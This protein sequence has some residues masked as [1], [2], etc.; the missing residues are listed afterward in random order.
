MQCDA[1]FPSAGRGAAFMILPAD[2]H[3]LPKW[4]FLLGDAVLL[5]T[6]WLID[7]DGRAPASGATLAAVVA[8]V[9]LGAVL[10]VI[11]F[12][13]EYARRQ[14]EALDERQRALEALSRTVAASA[15]Q[16]GIAAHGLHEISEL[17]Q[18]NLKA[19]EQLP[20][21]LQEKLTGLKNQRDGER[22]TDR[23]EFRSELA[24]SRAA[25]EE[26]LDRA[27]EKIAGITAAL[28]RL[29][30][31]RPSS[32]APANS[33]RAASS[34]PPDHPAPPPHEAETA[35]ASAGIPDHPV[36][37]APGTASQRAFA[38]E[39]AVPGEP[40]AAAAA[41]SS[42]G[43]GPA[44]RPLPPD[45]VPPT[46]PGIAPDSSDTGFAAGA[47]P[48]PRPERKRTPRKP[49]P[50]A[51]AADAAELPAAPGPSTPGESSSPAPAPAVPP[52]AEPAIPSSPQAE[53]SAAETA[54]IRSADGATRL[55][56]TAY[57]GI[58]N[59]LFIRGSGPGLSWD[60]GL[61]LQFVSIG[62]WR[63]ETP[64]SAAVQFK[65]FKN[66]DV[67]CLALGVQTIAAGHQHE[68]RATF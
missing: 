47:A 34:G 52:E 40:P 33:V 65:L 55:I 17:A 22:E 31:L 28:A 60:R 8:C 26:R 4:P 62:K 23:T 24:R 25:G 44:D 7:A 30:H 50:E 56:V 2:T 51:P 6:A 68:V 42:R 38:V 46:A 39:P 57:I 12:L 32:L 13:A 21:R 41:D 18:R 45:A 54:P 1:A 27:L 67:E 63:W 5:G 59:R 9:L 48:A 58:G 43:S 37:A 10:G 11:P 36:P 3:R 14:D 29:D 15:E 66:D 49:R 64:E 20:D 19:A 61:P 53:A 35:G 16:I